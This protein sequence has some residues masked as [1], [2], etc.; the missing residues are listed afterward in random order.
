MKIWRESPK[1]LPANTALCSRGLCFI[2]LSFD[3][4][5]E[6]RITFDCVKQLKKQEK[7]GDRLGEIIGKNKMGKRKR[8][9]WLF[10]LLWF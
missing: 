9:K 1:V 10:R 7:S 3:I 4:R 6:L 8:A 5:R 2:L